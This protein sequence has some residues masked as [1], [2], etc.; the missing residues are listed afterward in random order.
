MIDSRQL[1]R[2][3]SRIEM[4]GDNIRFA[5][6]RRF[7]RIGP[8][9]I[10][11]YRGYG[12]QQ[13]VSISG[14]VLEIARLDDPN[15]ED[16]L[17]QNF[18]AMLR[19]YSSKEIPFV[20]MSATFQQQ[21]IIIETDDDG[22]FQVTFPVDPALLSPE[23]LWHLVHFELLER[24][25][26]GQEKVT[27]VGEVVIPDSKSDF[28]IISDID[29]TVLISHTTQLFKVLKLS[30][31]GN[32]STRMP[33]RGVTTFY[34]ALQKGRTGQ[35]HNPFFYVSS[36]PWNIYD[37]LADFFSRNG[38]PKGPILLRDLGI[39][40]TKFIKEKHSA[41]KPVK[42]RQ[43]LNTYPDLP[44]ILVG[45]S[46]Q[47]DPEIYRQII[48]EF[49]GR[50]LTAYIR[51]ARPGRGG[52]T[53]KRIAALTGNSQVEMVLCIDTEAAA[54]HALAKGYIQAEQVRKDTIYCVS[55]YTTVQFRFVETQTEAR[56]PWA[57]SSQ[58][59]LS[60]MYR[61]MVSTI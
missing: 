51:D 23:Q 61:S 10:L 1:L 43:I 37:V 56:R 18:R 6:K 52:L 36:S 59:T 27:A 2:A 32:A 48:R 31:A 9:T 16:S 58:P 14:R 7:N 38:I 55:T 8:V 12:N 22:Y 53:V 50:I 4:A 11:P 33:F 21:T 42:I 15:P 17:W 46:G 29:D 13:Q 54:K 20:R 47:H 35:A 19:R 57:V 40:E 45:D 41:H 30:L 44:F 39:S 5:I 25:V 49:P 3:L 28:G 26:P 60:Q 34:E 24:I